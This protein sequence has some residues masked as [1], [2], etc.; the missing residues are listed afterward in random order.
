MLAL[1]FESLA[2]CPLDLADGR[3]LLGRAMSH[4]SGLN[5]EMIAVST[6]GLSTWC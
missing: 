4:E 3:A 1:L 5:V 6:F 2:V